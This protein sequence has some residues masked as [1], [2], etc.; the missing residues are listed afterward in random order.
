MHVWSGLQ[1]PSFEHPAAQNGDPSDATQAYCGP[2]HSSLAAHPTHATGMVRGG[3]A[4]PKDGTAVGE[5]SA[6]SGADDVASR[7]SSPPHAT[8]ASAVITRAGRDTPIPYR[9]FTVPVRSACHA[10]STTRR[11]AAMPA[12]MRS[13]LVA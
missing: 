11:I 2:P 3:P 13:S 12:A 10:A 7:D 6:G 4:S 9:T 1:K 8:S 5:A